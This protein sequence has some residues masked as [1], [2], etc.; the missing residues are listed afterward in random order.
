MGIG[1]VS[2]QVLNLADT[3]WR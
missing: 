3:R 1:G 2:P